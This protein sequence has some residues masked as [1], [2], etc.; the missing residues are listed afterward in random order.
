MINLFHLFLS[1]PPHSHSPLN[2]G[3]IL[4]RFMPLRALLVFPILSKIE[5]HQCFRWY[6]D[7]KMTGRWPELSNP[8]HDVEKLTR[9]TYLQDT[10]ADR[11]R[12]YFW[13]LISI[14]SK[15]LSGNLES[16][17]SQP[18]KLQHFSS[19]GSIQ[20]RIGQSE[21]GFN[22]LVA[23]DR[24]TIAWG[25]NRRKLNKINLETRLLS[26]KQKFTWKNYC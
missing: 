13:I 8:A 22:L 20:A 18:I 3:P 2:I 10:E 21:R 1:R 25:R 5:G 19:S 17:T 11:W 23:R 16:V 6:I 15:I 7:P 24:T 12:N 4:S 26:W 14:F 9:K